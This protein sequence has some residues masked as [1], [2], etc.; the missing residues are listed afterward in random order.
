MCRSV[1][2]YNG[3]VLGERELQTAPGDPG[4]GS[5]PSHTDTSGHVRPLLRLP[6]STVLSVPAPPHRGPRSALPDVPLR[7]F[8]SDF[9][10]RLLLG[11]EPACV[12]WDVGWWQRDAWG[13]TAAHGDVFRV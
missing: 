6:G 12:V 7:R 11:P 1:S 13:R 5:V 4:P 2:G 10:A 3:S 8:P 9:L